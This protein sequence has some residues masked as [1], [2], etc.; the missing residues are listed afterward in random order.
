[1]KT[2]Q[3]LSLKFFSKM[4]NEF[5]IQFSAFLDFDVLFNFLHGLSRGRSSFT[6]SR[7]WQYQFSR[8]DAI[9]FLRVCF[10]RTI[11]RS[12]ELVCVNSRPWQPMRSNRDSNRYP[13][14]RYL[15]PPLLFPVAEAAESLRDRSLAIS[16]LFAL[17]IFSPRPDPLGPD[18]RNERSGKPDRGKQKTQEI[19]RR[20]SDE[21]FLVFLID[22]NFQHKV[23][24]HS[25]YCEFPRYAKRR[26]VGADKTAKSAK[27]YKPPAFY[28]RLFP[29]PTSFSTPRRSKNMNDRR[30][31]TATN[32]TR[33]KN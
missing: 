12:S 7:T 11:E 5:R 25:P 10:S 3:F 19:T 24:P 22:Q 31:P 15:L 29:N 18:T 21:E 8:K 17:A 28:R 2:R 20:N 23:Q 16:L 32:Y 26:R 33:Q 6:E 27:I 4:K 13:L 14:D 30:N 9:L 1:M